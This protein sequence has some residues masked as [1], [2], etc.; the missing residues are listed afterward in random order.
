M[1]HLIDIYDFTLMRTHRADGRV[2]TICVKSDDY[3]HLCQRWP[4]SK[5]RTKAVREASFQ[6]DL[7]HPDAPR[8]RLA[9]RSLFIRRALGR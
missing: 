5:G 3:F 6:F 1:R 8:T 2:T 7:Q 4:D 9:N